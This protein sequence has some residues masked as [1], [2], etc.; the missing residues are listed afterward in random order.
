MAS[1]IRPENRKVGSLVHFHPEIEQKGTVA[2]IP[3]Q[4]DD[5]GC[6]FRASEKPAASRSVITVSPGFISYFKRSGRSADLRESLWSD[7]MRTPR[8]ACNA[9]DNRSS[10]TSSATNR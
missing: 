9:V 8:W 6:S 4:E 10:A 5:G 3:V 7:E 2:A 1:Q